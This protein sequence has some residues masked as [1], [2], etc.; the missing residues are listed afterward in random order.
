MTNH[1]ARQRV[2]RFREGRKS[3]GERQTNVWLSEPISEALDQAVR[4][5]IFPSKQ[6]AISHAL[7]TVFIRKEAKTVT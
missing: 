2:Q 5:G 1:S 4:S 3:R 7:E 6:V